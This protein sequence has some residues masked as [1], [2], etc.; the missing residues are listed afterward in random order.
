MGKT[1]NNGG[2]N[3]W[4]L[5][6]G[7]LLGT[8][9]LLGELRKEKLN[10][11]IVLITGGSKG[12][13]LALAQEYGGQG[14]QIAITARSEEELQEAQRLLREQGISAYTHPCDVSKQDEVNQLIHDVTN[15]YG[16]ID[17]LVNNAGIIAIGPF[18]T[19]TI[20]DF[21]ETMNSMY[22]GTVYASLAVI[23]QMQRRKT[24]H[25]VN[26]TSVGGK[27]SIPRLLTYS[28][29]KFATIGFSEGLHAEIA[30]DGI[31]VTTV[32]PGLMRTGSHVGALAKGDT[33]EQDYTLFSFMADTPG[34]SVSAKRAAKQIVAATQRGDAELII[35]L[36]AQ[37]LSAFHGLFPGTTSQILAGVNRLLPKTDGTN[38]ERYSG[39]ES[40]TPITK[41]NAIG[42]KTANEYNQ[43]LPEEGPKHS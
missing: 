26:I 34:L 19:L 13:G 14:A 33:H 21:Q 1:S 4:L 7:L 10:G 35:S 23:P 40:R 39:K 24:G 5:G 41:F 8:T 15:H 11:K 28:S 38:K 2:L 27:V 31:K 20:E 30:Q 43:F 3:S 22:W 32:A 16:Q 17:V 29:A 9:R 36:P 12:L 42:N 37:I 6:A 18:N 25:I